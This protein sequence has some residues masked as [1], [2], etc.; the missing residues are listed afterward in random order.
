MPKTAFVA[1]GDTRE[2]LR[3]VIVSGMGCDRVRC[4]DADFSKQWSVADAQPTFGSAGKIAPST[5]NPEFVAVTYTSV[6]T[7]AM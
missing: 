1:L 3:R 2:V 6:A 4:H 5:A 7:R